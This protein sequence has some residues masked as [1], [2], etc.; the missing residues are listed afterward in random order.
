MVGVLH[1]KHHHPQKEPCRP[2]GFSVLTS[3]QYQ[4]RLPLHATSYDGVRTVLQ[5]RRAFHIV[6]SANL[7][8]TGFEIATIKEFTLCRRAR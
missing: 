4:R 5:T 7:K 3:T 6:E 8:F 2:A 1:T